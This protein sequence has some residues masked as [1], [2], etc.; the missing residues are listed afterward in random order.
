M[1]PGGLEARP[2]P[3]ESPT[4]REATD[5]QTCE[6]RRDCADDCDEGLPPPVRLT[7][8]AQDPVNRTS[9]SVSSARLLFVSVPKLVCRP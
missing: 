4:P 2:I 7:N 3:L 6:L 8:L 1:L 9:T 5:Y